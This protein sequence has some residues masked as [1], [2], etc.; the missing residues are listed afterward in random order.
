MSWIS[1]Y[2]SCR[3]HWGTPAP[4]TRLIHLLRAGNPRP[5]RTEQGK[6]GS[7]CRA[8]GSL[9][10]YVN[11]DEDTSVGSSLSAEAGFVECQAEI[12]I[13]AHDSPALSRA[14]N[15]IYRLKGNR[16]FTAT[17]SNSRSV[18]SVFS[19]LPIT[20]AVP[21]NRQ[22][23]ALETNGTVRACWDSLQDINRSVFDQAGVNGPT[24]PRPRA[25]SA[26]LR[27]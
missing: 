6:P 12:V 14:E 25:A 20:L 15:G 19:F 16:P 22:S 24:T 26:L 10:L 17:C 8:M 18:S 11:G 9:L 2:A 1:P 5:F 13:N 21:G 27:S 3:A 23:V 7:S 4:P